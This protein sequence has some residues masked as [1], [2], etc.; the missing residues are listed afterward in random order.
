MITRIHL[1]NFRSHE[2]SEIELKPISLLI[3]PV[4]AGKSNLFKGLLLIQNSIH[5]SLVELFPPGLGEFH[6]VRSRWADETDPIGFEVDAE[7]IDG[8]P[9]V[10]GRYSLKI[11]TGPEGLYILEETLQKQSQDAI[12]EWVFQRHYR[13]NYLGE[14]GDVSPYDP[15]ILNR[16]WHYDQRVN[17]LKEG[18]K[19]VKEFAR[20]LSSFGYY[21]LETSTL[22]GLGNGQARDRL[23]YTGTGLPDFLAGLKFSKQ[24]DDIQA[25]ESILNQMREVLPD[26]DEIIVT[27]VGSDEQGLAISF[28]GHRG[29][30]TAPDLSDGTLFTLGLL[31]I[32]QCPRRPSLLCL[33]EPETGLHPGR[34]RW[35]FEKLLEQVYPNDQSSPVQIILSTHSPSVVD[36]F[37]NMQECVNVFESSQG[38]TQIKSLHQIQQTLHQDAKQD[39]PIGTLWATGLYEN[40]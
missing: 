29:Y 25:F 3:G 33:E 5:R 12:W 22:K 19:F 37:G 20:C 16:V 7:E 8:Y 24:N 39:E 30:I 10:R 2:D 32:L 9:G 28:T 18:P 11:G 27:Q 6:W 14:Y 15:S 4:A 26:L 1:R 17:M 34:L 40:L 21:H 31:C 35:L 38:R 36:L 23:G 13:K